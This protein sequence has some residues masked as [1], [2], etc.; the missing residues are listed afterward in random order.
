MDAGLRDLDAFGCLADESRRKLYE[1]VAAS[2]Q[3]VTREDAAARAGISR[4]LAAYHLDRLVDHGLLDVDREPA[5]RRHGRGT[6]RPPKRYRRAL[7]ELELHAPPRDYRLL[8]E[9]LV[10]GAAERP[11]LRGA[12]EDAAGKVGERLGADAGSL[13]AVLLRHGYEPVDDRGTLRLRNCPFRS[14]A[15][16]DREV[17]C[18]INLALLQGVLAGVGLDRSRASLAPSDGACC[19]AI[20]P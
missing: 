17:V 16:V 5:A 19:V 7:R 8:A 14:L 2:P 4:S 10:R 6:G 11:E 9:V 15:V 12:I 1:I 20:R 13:E 18:G 3:P